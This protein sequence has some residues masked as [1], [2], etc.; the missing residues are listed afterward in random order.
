LPDVAIIN[1]QAYPLS[2]QLDA[3]A[4]EM[5][6]R[7]IEAMGVRVATKVSV[8]KLLTRT[9]DDGNDVFTGF[10]LSSGELMEADMVMCVPP[11]RST[12]AAYKSAP[13]FAVGIQPRDDLA[14]KSGIACQKKG[15]IIVEDDLGTSAKDVYAIGE[16]ASWRGNTY[17]G[18]LR[19]ERAFAEDAQGLIAPGIEMADVRD[20]DASRM[21]CLTPMQILAFNLTQ[22]QTAV[23]S[24]K[25][26]KMNDP[27][28]STKLKLMGVDVASF[29]DFFADARMKEALEAH[30]TKLRSM[31]ANEPTSA[32]ATQ[33]AVDISDTRPS[34]QLPVVKSAT[35]APPQNGAATPRSR[36][37]GPG[38]DEPIKCLT[39]R[40]PFSSTYKKCA[41]S[42][43]SDL[44]LPA[45]DDAQTSLLPTASTSSAV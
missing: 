1:R 5:V 7:K 16:C 45:A 21:E 24:F 23:G 15:G 42:C 18:P 44:V 43:G 39:Y 20:P 25:P 12:A 35:A 13:S 17:V 34:E 4:G 32:A 33:P 36:H 30:E 10:E 2:R 41:S 28:L 14:R 40:D 38:R 6:L 11:S 8:T 29:G 22:T 9:E 3:D 31:T 26:R 27:D 19:A 37:G